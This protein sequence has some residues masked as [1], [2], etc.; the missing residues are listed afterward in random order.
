MTLTLAEMFDVEICDG[1][2][3]ER[4]IYRLA[5]LPT[6]LRERVLLERGLE[7]IHWQSPDGC[8]WHLRAAYM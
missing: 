3:S 7:E 5:D 4:D 6:V 2:E 8:K 1:H